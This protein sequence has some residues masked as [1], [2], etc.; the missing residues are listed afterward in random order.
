MTIHSSF[1]WISA[2]LTVYQDKS[3]ELA[4]SELQALRLETIKESGCIQFEV[5]PNQEDPRKFT[6]W[7]KWIDKDALTQHFAEP[8]TQHYLS[9]ELTEVD[10]IERLGETL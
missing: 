4:R 3:T 10:Y 2:G 5:R 6:L 1:L 8:H 7:E 9:L